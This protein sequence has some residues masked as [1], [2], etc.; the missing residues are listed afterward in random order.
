MNKSII[1]TTSFVMAVAIL[2]GCTN[3]SSNFGLNQSMEKVIIGVQINQDSAL[4]QIAK[5]KGF[6]EKHGINAEISEFT[7]GKFAFQ[8]MLANSADFAVSGDVPITLA[9]MNGNEFY[10]I[11][12]VG[13]NPNNSPLLVADDGTNSIKE[14]FS[15]SKRKIS[16][17]IGGTPEFSL[18]LMLRENN[19]NPNNIE[20]IAQKPEEM[21]GAF[22]KKSID[23]F[24]IFEPYI[25]IAEEKSEIKTKIFKLNPSTYPT[26]YILSSTKQIVDNKPETVKKVLAALKEAE[27]FVKTNPSEAAEIVSKRSKIELKIIQ[28]A[29][30][31]YDYTMQISEQ[32]KQNM[33]MQSDWAIE[34]KKVKEPYQTD[35]STIFRTEF[36]SEAN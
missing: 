1:L 3:T 13:T 15:K 25:S 32:L 34:T 5:E 36:I 19:I 14:F 4:V 22:S 23:G 33:K 29:M 20:I 24:V 11:S 6:F 10:V 2:F 30:Q 35:F 26:K 8:A 31:D 28:K 17:S 21:V 16:T 9:K 27:R 12:E 18:Y 7:A